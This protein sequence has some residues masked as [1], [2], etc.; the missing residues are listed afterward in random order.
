MLKN[1][2]EKD[3]HLSQRKDEREK[4]GVLRMLLAS[5][6]NKEIEFRPSNKK[7]E[8]KDVLDIIRAEVKKRKEAI[9]L[10]KKGG[11]EDLAKK[12]EQA[13][14]ILQSYLP[15]EL[16]DEEIKEIIKSKIS[17]LNAQGLSDFGKVMGAVMKE[18]SGRAEGEKVAKIVK[19]IL[20][21]DK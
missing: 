10:F 21:A 2:I 1:K 9:F 13:L 20:G 8:D 4:I 15:K 16:K 17:E 19:E 18:I 14:E 6:H 7:L 5:L 11:R 12:E 3:Y